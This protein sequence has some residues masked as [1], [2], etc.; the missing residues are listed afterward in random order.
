MIEEGKKLIIRKLISSV[1]SNGDLSYLHYVSFLFVLLQIEVSC[2]GY[3]YPGDP[4]I[5]KGSCGVSATLFLNF[6]IF[7]FI[8]SMLIETSDIPC[9]ITLFAWK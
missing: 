1:A 7:I 2:E 4:F 6:I 3:S 9:C 8:L 5:L